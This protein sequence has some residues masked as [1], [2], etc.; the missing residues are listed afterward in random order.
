MKTPKKT[1]TKKRVRR[2]KKEL[3]T[4]LWTTLEK[5]IIEKGFD[6]ITILGLAEE[7]GFKTLVIYNRFNNIDELLEEYVRKYDY[8]LRD[9]IQLCAETPAKENFK[10][11]IVD[12]INELYDNEI[13]QRVLLWG[14]N[15]THRITRHLALS[16]EADSA[17]LIEYYNGKLPNFNG[18][19]AVII[20]GIYYLILQRRIATF[21]N[22]DYNS[23]QGK[24]IMI[25]TVEY[26][27][28]RLFP[29]NV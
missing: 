27:I 11:L 18:V 20:A 2:T 12:L 7:A 5:Q 23:E 16:R 17:Q 28:D 10:K 14:L 1:N 29:E 15:D 3:E 25:D 26:M 6:N 21:C 4:A 13:M 24:K 22:T 9:I 19:S 8:W